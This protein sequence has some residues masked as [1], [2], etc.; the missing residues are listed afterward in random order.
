MMYF[1]ERDIHDTLGI[2]SSVIAFSKLDPWYPGALLFRKRV[3]SVIDHDLPEIIAMND[4]SLPYSSPA[5]L[6]V[7]KIKELLDHNI[8]TENLN[9][10]A[11]YR[12]G[13]YLRL[14]PLGYRCLTVAF[15]DRLFVY[16]VHEKI[17]D[18]HLARM[19]ELGLLPIGSYNVLDQ[20]DFNLRAKFPS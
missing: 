20:V 7:E 10:L 4:P 6:A 3:P 12:I 15:R 5:P 8:Y 16:F 13:S 14:K 9:S 2:G 17:W 1:A 19:K 18:Y 11:Y